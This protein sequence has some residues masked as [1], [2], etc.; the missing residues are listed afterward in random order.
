MASRWL[1]SMSTEEILVCIYAG[2]AVSLTANTLLRH[3]KNPSRPKP[4][5][6][7]LGEQKEEEAALTSDFKIASNVKVAS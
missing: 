2:D 1:L 7:P 3:V 5:F 6:C 4:L